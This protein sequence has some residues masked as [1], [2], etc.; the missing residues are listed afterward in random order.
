MVAALIALAAC[1]TAARD[2]PDGLYAEIVTSRGEILIRL[3]PER[4][5]L[6]VMNF[7][8][9]AEGT[10]DNDHAPGKPFYDGL[11]FHRVEPGFVI[12]GGDPRGD[13]TGGPGYRF[14]TETHPDLT[15]DKPG[16][17][18]MA[19]SGPD[20]NGSQF[21]ITKRPTPH[22]DGGYNIF[23]EVVEGMNVV[24]AIQRGDRI[25][26]V[27]ILRAG[28]AAAGYQAS[29]ERFQELIEA[30]ATER[31]AARARILDEE[32]AALRDRFP[33]IVEH[34]EG[35]LLAQLQTGSGEPPRQ[36]QAIEI[37]IV[38]S[39]PDGTQLDNTRDTNS[40]QRIVYLRDRLIRGLEMAVGTM[41]VGE[42]TVA[43][44]PPNLWNA[45][46]PPGIPAGSYVVFDIERI[47]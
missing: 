38:F 23:G 46:R 12:Q 13:G 5:P 40:P 17:V 32:L 21:Y 3:E 29:T 4:A 41:L 16:I 28:D 27:R 14:P 2:V 35:L 45:G 1:G 9:L 43:I 8:G 31:E 25:R 34:E 11:L 44:V 20:T 26:E 39:L 19:N 37:H 24:T 42:R 6:T 36:G 47:Q 15:H 22:L 7:V 30:V 18:A 10:I 33:T